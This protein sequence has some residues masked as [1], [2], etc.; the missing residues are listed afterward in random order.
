MPFSATERGGAVV[1]DELSGVW[2][3][4]R[5]KPYDPIPDYDP[6]GE[7]TV[8]VEYQRQDRDNWR[9]GIVETERTGRVRIVIEGVRE[10]VAPYEIAIRQ[11]L[12]SE[13]DAEGK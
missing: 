8:E 9:L 7:L 13:R 2:D 1:R 3:M 4:P 12:E 5:V 11:L 6:Y 10:R